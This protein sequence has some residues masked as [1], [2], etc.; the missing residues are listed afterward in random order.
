MRI[1]P[2]NAITETNET[3]N[4]VNFGSFIVLTSSRVLQLSGTSGNDVIALKGETS[5]NG[6]IFIT[7]INGQNYAV[8]FADVS[9][10]ELRCGAGD[11]VI[12]VSGLPFPS[13]YIDGGDGNDK[14]QGGDGNETLVGGA[15]KDQIDGGGGNDR[16]NGNGG[17]DKLFGGA[18]ADRLYGYAGNDYLDGGS[19]GDRLEG[20]PGLDTMLGQS[21]N[22]IFFTNDGEADQL[23]GGSGKDSSFADGFDTLSSIESQF[24][25]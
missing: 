17:N 18:G 21:G 14:I 25:T 20:G 13:L 9:G 8:G 1:D 6:S 19:S 12:T 24:I 5:S 7:N 2:H 23:F 10:V 11:D 4:D 22:D 15:G 3:N 16:L